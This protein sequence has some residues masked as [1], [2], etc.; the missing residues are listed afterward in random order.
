MT[1]MSPKQL[2]SSRTFCSLLLSMMIICGACREDSIYDGAGI[3]KSMTIRVSLPDPVVTTPMGRAGATD[4]DRIANLNVV[5]ADGTGSIHSI[6]YYDGNNLEGADPAFSTIDGGLEV[7][8]SEE[9]IRTN[10]LA[11]K[12]IYL[13]ANYGSNLSTRR[14]ENIEALRS[15]KQGSSDTPGVPNGCMMFAEVEDNGETHT[16]GSTTGKT[17]KAELKRTVAMVTVAIDGSGLNKN[18]MI[19]PTAISLHRVPTDCYIGKP[20]N[21]VTAGENGRIAEIGEFKDALQYSWDPI[22]GTATQTGG[23]SEWRLHGTATGG[24]YSK[25][26]YGDQSIAPLFLFE[27]LHGEDFGAPIDKADQSGKRPAGTENN[28]DAIDAATQHCSYLQVDA[29][30]M[31]VD[32]N[33]NPQFSGK[34]SFRFFLGHD[35]FKNFDVTRNH[36]Y[37]VT[38]AISGNGV[39]EGGQ[40]GTDNNGNTILEANPDDI[41]WRVDSDLSTASFITGDVNL[42]A[43]GEYFYVHV[44]ADPGVTWN[45][46]ATGDLFVWAYGKVDGGAASWGSLAAGTTSVAPIDNSGTL[47]FYAQPL[48]YG[49]WAPESQSITLTLNPS[50][51]SPTSITIKQYSPLRITLSATDYPYIQKIFGKSEVDFLMDRIDRKALPWGFYGEVLDKNHADGFDNTFHLIDET[52]D[53]GNDHRTVAKKYLPFGT[54]DKTDP[55]MGGSAMIYALMLY[56]NQSTTPSGDPATGVLQQDFPAIDRSHD[57]N[58]TKY[59]WSVPS[60]EE[61]QI[62]EKAARDKGILDENFPILDWFKYWTSDAVTR[63][64]DSKGGYTHAFTYQFNQGL[65]ALTEDGVYPRDQ[66]VLRTERLRFRLISVAPDNLPPVN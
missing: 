66:R 50:Q 6:H 47:L 4:F 10:D 9:Y 32:D 45:V 15:L 28:P 39:T 64:S 60:I 16:H 34:V 30:Y 26:N 29:N 36:Y 52:P 38:L 65:D 59:Y 42:N 19:T 13:V 37:Q 33:G 53:C 25:D 11:S 51:G 63:L 58:K 12:T 46:T 21:D 7:H 23:Y 35:E 5:V 54:A 8:F 56:E 55:D 48:V 57:Y 27:N 49:D 61:W 3:G 14:L 41:T 2:F 31:K 22:V 24:H 1:D 20:N 40:V 62:I 44:A 18:I 43:S 17:L